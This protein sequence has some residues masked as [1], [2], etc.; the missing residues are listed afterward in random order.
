MSDL[1]PCIIIIALVLPFVTIAM[2]L[3]FAVLGKYK[4]ISIKIRRIQID[5]EK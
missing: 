1:S 2:T 5:M 3:A 4:K